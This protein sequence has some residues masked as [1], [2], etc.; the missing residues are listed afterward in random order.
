MQAAS[1]DAEVKGD[2]LFNYR[3]KKE[4]CMYVEAGMFAA[5]KILALVFGLEFFIAADVLGKESKEFQ[6]E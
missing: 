6:I 4:G 5:V 1:A 2:K 3:F